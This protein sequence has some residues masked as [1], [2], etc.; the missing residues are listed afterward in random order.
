M[1]KLSCRAVRGNYNLLT[2]YVILE[3]QG[4]TVGKWVREQANLTFNAECAAGLVYLSSPPPFF[5]DT[6]YKLYENAFTL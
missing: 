1:F 4:N 5:P 6:F 2:V 3:Q